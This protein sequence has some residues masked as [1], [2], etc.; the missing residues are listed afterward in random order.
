MSRRSSRLCGER[1]RR[2]ADRFT[3]EAGSDGNEYVA[4]FSSIPGS[5]AWQWEVLVVAPTDDFVG[6]L[7]RT[8]RLLIW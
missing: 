6:A 5:I 2:E 3:F 4:L 8:N 1:A 7:K